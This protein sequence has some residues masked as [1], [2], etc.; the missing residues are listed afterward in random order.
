LKAAT[1]RT[2]PLP[3]AP[4]AEPPRKIT[5]EEREFMAFR[6]LRMARANQRHE[7]ARKVRAAKASLISHVQIG[8]SLTPLQ[9]EEEEAAKKK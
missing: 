6:A 2:F 4:P 7:G 3:A 5:D 8:E 9:K 1:T